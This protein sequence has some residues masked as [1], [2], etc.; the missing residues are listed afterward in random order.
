MGIRK[1]DEVPP[2]CF[3]HRRCFLIQD[4][5]QRRSHK[6]IWREKCELQPQR[7][8]KLLQPV[9]GDHR[10]QLWWDSGAST[11]Q[12]G[13]VLCCRVSLGD[14]VPFWMAEN[15]QFITPDPNSNPILYY[16][17]WEISESVGG[18]N[19][20]VMN[21]AYTSGIN[22]PY[23]IPDQWKYLFIANWYVDPTLRFTCTKTRQQWEEEQSN[24]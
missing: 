21:D 3:S 20:G 9:H 11:K 14:M 16:M 4:L 24:L 7:E 18:L 15:R 6:E 12:A 22:C 13:Q 19:A 5:L 23:E 10:D 8:D 17:K 2:C 1:K